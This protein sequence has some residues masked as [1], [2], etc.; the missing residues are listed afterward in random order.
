MVSISSRKTKMSTVARGRRT[1]RSA[2]RAVGEAD[3]EVASHQAS[4]SVRHA[5]L[6]ADLVDQ[7]EVPL[8]DGDLGADAGEVDDGHAH[9]VGL[10]VFGA[11]ARRLD[12]PIWRGSST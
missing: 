8:F 10:E 3:A 4:R 5:E 2:P 11:W 6:V 9:A 12:L 1:S 7:A